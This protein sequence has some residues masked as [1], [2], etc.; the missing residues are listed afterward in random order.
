[1]FED[2]VSES[3]G[4]SSDGCI[5]IDLDKYKFLPLMIIKQ[6]FDKINTFYESCSEFNEFKKP[7]NY[8]MKNL[9]YV[10]QQHG[11]ADDGLPL[12]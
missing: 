11:K 6:Y 1:M 3:I 4:F 10:M 2:Q 5:G 9:V 8:F 7:D 12:I